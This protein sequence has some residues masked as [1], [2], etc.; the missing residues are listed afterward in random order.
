MSFEMKKPP[1]L[2]G[3]GTQPPRKPQTKMPFREKREGA[4]QKR[5]RGGTAIKVQAKAAAISQPPDSST[6][7]S[8]A[9]FSQP[10]TIGD[11]GRASESP[12]SSNVSQT[13]AGLIP[14]QDAPDSTTAGIALESSP[15][16]SQQS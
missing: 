6:S 16:D 12:A 5:A 2:G 15:P 8:M 1:T 3:G 13:P 4:Q 14:Q 9:E 7:T 10:A 11:E